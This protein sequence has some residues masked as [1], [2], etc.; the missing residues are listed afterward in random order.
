MILAFPNPSRLT[1]NAGLLAIPATW[2]RSAIGPLAVAIWI[3]RETAYRF[4]I[5]R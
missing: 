2:N 4:V 1:E 3:R 5:L